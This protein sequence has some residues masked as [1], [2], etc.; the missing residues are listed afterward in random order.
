[1]ANA[2]KPRLATAWKYAKVEL[3]PPGPSEFGKMGTEFGQFTKS[4]ATGGFMKLTTKVILLIGSHYTARHP[5][6][7][8]FFIR[9][10]VLGLKLI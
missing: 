10:Y 1:M 2:A 3:K 9:L 4:I 5:D 6:I 7:M 8:L